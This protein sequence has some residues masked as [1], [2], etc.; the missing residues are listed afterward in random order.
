[1]FLFQLKTKYRL[2]IS[3]LFVG[4]FTLNPLCTVLPP[5]ISSAAKPVVANGR[6]IAFL[7][8]IDLRSAL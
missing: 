2:Q 4:I 7:A 6:A 8:S 1:M 3:K 5:F